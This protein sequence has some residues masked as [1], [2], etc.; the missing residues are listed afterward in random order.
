MMPLRNWRAYSITFWIVFIG[1][2]LITIFALSIELGQYFY[3]IAVVQ[4]Q[5]MQP[6]KGLRLSLI[7]RFPRIAEI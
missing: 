7:S 4:K 1:L 5:P 6:P 2:L 3:A